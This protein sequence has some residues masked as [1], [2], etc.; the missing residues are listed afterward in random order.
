MLTVNAASGFGGGGLHPPATISF[1]SSAIYSAGTTASTT[2]SS[3]AL[4]SAAATRQ[5]I[6]GSSQGSGGANIT[7]MT[8]GGDSATKLL[9]VTD[10]GFQAELWWLEKPTGTTGDVVIAVDVDSEFITCA[11][12]ALY[13]ASTTANATASASNADP[14]STTIAVPAEGVVVAQSCYNASVSVTWTGPTEDFDAYDT[15]THSGASLAYA[16]AQSPL[17][18]ISDQGAGSIREAL[19]VASF[20]KK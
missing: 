2:F 18:V 4:G 3:Q 16:T 19:A 11:I 13:N 9:R 5:I 12:W 20:S 1:E 17:T 14:L 6:V 15:H 8:V 10:N 7:A